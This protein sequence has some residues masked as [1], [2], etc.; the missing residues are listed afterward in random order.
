[1]MNFMGGFFVI[2]SL[3]KMV[4]IAGFVDSFVTY[5]IVAM[6]YGNYARAYPFIELI[7]GIGYLAGGPEQALN[8]CTLLL[9]CVGSVGV[10]NALKSKRQIQCA[11]LGSALNLPMT[12]VTLVENLVM[13]FM[14][15]AM[16]LFY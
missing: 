3:F 4:N 14:A 1:M 9:M 5:D 2:F 6:R 11:C 16:L 8:L 12:K 15:L 13:G 7:L 10:Y